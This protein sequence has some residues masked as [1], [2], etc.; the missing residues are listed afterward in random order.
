M[1]HH[2]GVRTHIGIEVVNKLIVSVV[3]YEVINIALVLNSSLI[4]YYV[5]VRSDRHRSG[6]E[7][8]VSVELI[9]RHTL[10]SVLRKDLCYE[11]I[12]SN[13]TEEVA[14]AESVV[15]ALDH[16]KLYGFS[17][18]LSPLNLEITYINNSIIVVGIDQLNANDRLLIDRSLVVLSTRRNLSLSVPYAITLINLDKLL[19]VSIVRTNSVRLGRS[20]EVQC[21]TRLSHLSLSELNC[22]TVL[23]IATGNHLGQ[24]QLCIVVSILRRMSLLSII[25][26][27]REVIVAICSASKLSNRLSLV[28]IDQRCNIRNYRV[29]LELS[30]VRTYNST[31]LALHQ[32]SSSDRSLQCANPNHR[33]NVINGCHCSTLNNVYG[34]NTTLDSVVNNLQSGSCCASLSLV[35][36]EYGLLDI[37]SSNYLR[38]NGIINLLSEVRSSESLVTLLSVSLFTTLSPLGVSQSLE[39]NGLNAIL[40]QIG[41]D[42]Q[43]GQT[44]V[45]ILCNLLN[46]CCQLLCNINRNLAVVLHC[47]C[48]SVS[49]LLIHCCGSLVDLSFQSVLGYKACACQ[50]SI[51]LSLERLFESLTCCLNSGL[52]SLL[53]SLCNNCILNTVESCCYLCQSLSSCIRCQS[54]VQVALGQETIELSLNGCD[55]LFESFLCCLHISEG[56][57][58]GSLLAFQISDILFCTCLQSCNLRRHCGV[59]TLQTVQRALQ[60]TVL[61]LD[62]CDLAGSQLVNTTVQISDILII[63]RT[64][65]PSQCHSCE[66]EGY[67]RSK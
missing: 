25:V 57:L 28:A 23:H 46:S 54:S 5:V 53:D 29:L 37:L 61:R 55:S 1:P 14:V 26:S 52:S 6:F 38:T 35:E 33:L 22:I 36:Y 40:V 62:R 18:N 17:N 16:A 2:S 13:S 11:L 20:Y 42:Q 3:S 10:I 32:M 12:P 66:E 58:N 34:Q 24:V 44:T 9:V 49:N 64:T 19:L 21:K 50:C 47:L 48:N 56:L 59:S 51:K 39:L 41:N 4:A 63:I 60:R 31:F 45:Q 67:D 27:S 7:V 15:E 30:P 43:A 8:V 65:D